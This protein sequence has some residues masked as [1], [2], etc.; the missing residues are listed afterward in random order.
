MRRVFLGIVLVF[1]ASATAWAAC[2]DP[3][4]FNPVEAGNTCC[5]V[6]ARSDI[7]VSANRLYAAKRNSFPGG[8]SSF[9]ITD[10]YNIQPKAG[11]GDSGET[12]YNWPGSVA[13]SNSGVRYH[14]YADSSPW[15]WRFR[16]DVFGANFLAFFSGGSSVYDLDI[17]TDDYAHVVRANALMVI[18]VN[19]P[20]NP[21]LDNELTDSTNPNFGTALRDI[22][23]EGSTVYLAGSDKLIAVDVTTP[24][25]PVEKGN[26]GITGA[27]RVRVIGNRA[28]VLGLQASNYK[29]HIVDVTDPNSLSSVSITTL[30]DLA[31]QAA[32]AVCG[33]YAF[34]ADLAS[35]SGGTVHSYDISD[36]T[37][38]VK[39]TSVSS[40][41]LTGVNDLQ[42]ND[43]AVF[44]ISDS[45]RR[46]VAFDTETSA[47]PAI[48]TCTVAGQREWDVTEGLYKFCTGT[49]WISMK[50]SG[51]LGSC[52]GSGTAEMQYDGGVTNYKFCDGTNW[53]P[54]GNNG[55][56]GSCAGTTVGTREYDT[57]AKVMKWCDGTNWI[58]M[59]GVPIS[60]NKCT[61]VTST[62]QKGGL[63]GVTG[64]DAICETQA[65]AGGLGGASYMAW[66]ST[67]A[68]DAPNT[69][70]TKSTTP[71]ELTMG[72]IIANDWT[73]LTDGTL[74]NPIDRDEN[75]VLVSAADNV[76]TCVGTGA[77][78]NCGLAGSR[79]S[80][81]TSSGGGQSG[82]LGNTNA[83]NFQWT[84]DTTS[85]ACTASNHLY[86]FEQ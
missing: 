10:I 78:A 24:T 19:D 5:N 3:G 33:N 53:I 12:G 86:C 29:L 66:I 18:D 44:A 47:S 69:R 54:V 76:W 42:C 15:D 20:V 55:T 75:G 8:Y 79:C 25:A 81:W 30:T 63:G 51:T 60:P 72:T 35:G 23:V 9:D 7:N 14:F 16:A 84:A 39:I 34:A 36:E 11:E 43:E 46:I 4:I 26:I 67:G 80:D 62:T 38:P 58:D 64:A 6:G 41:V 52:A 13:V 1:L 56:L 83:T 28:Y 27:S 57:T 59:T 21:F 74:N 70:F 49:T 50:G 45:T 85:E 71:Y 37:A 40:T 22:E 17:E 82:L 65:A 77:L 61:F 48:G 68:A 73:D 31:S 32:I 2:G